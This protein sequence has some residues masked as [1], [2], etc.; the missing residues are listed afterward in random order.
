MKEMNLYRYVS[1][2]LL[3]ALGVAF[4]FLHVGYLS[5]WGM[6][7][8]IVAVPVLLALFLFDVKHSL[9]V[10]VLIS[11]VIAISAPSGFIGAI[12]KFL[13]TL[14]MFIVL[15]MGAKWKGLDLSKISPLAL[16]L[17]AAIAI[18]A[19]ITVVANYYWALPIWLNMTTAE[20][21]Q[22]IPWW[23]IAGLN[24]AQGV[25]EVSIAWALAFKFKLVE[26]YGS[27]L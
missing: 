2:A 27:K 22:T 26:R 25:V 21:F 8:D 18:R 3:A 24:A 23:I 15:G 19:V 12:M 14:P 17:V 6:W 20:A 5:P 1:V 7:I 11:V 16:L 10:A 9:A 4:Q 13:G